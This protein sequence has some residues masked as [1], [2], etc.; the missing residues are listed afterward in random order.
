MSLSL[1][2][3]KGGGRYS[4]GKPGKLPEFPI[5]A[6]QLV[7]FDRHSGS[8]CKVEL[9]GPRGGRSRWVSGSYESETGSGDRPFG[10]LWPYNALPPPARTTA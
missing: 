8:I 2:D 4:T 1:M 6:L 5:D 7:F 9:D 3:E 10:L